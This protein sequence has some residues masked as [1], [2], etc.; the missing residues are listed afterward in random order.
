MFIEKAALPMRYS[1]VC[2]VDDQSSWMAVEVAEEVA[3][4]CTPPNWLIAKRVL[5][6]EPIAK[7]GA[8]RPF[9]FIEREAHG[10]V[11]AP[12]LSVPAVVPKYPLPLA[13][14]TVEDA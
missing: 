13:E 14:L 8:V 9:A 5:V 3:K 2:G 4:S 12:T 11:V 6:E 7:A 10:V 1:T